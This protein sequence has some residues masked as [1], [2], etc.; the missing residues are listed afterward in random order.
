M[1]L[2]F[3]KDVKE[4]KGLTLRVVKSPV[5]DKLETLYKLLGELKGGYALIFCISATE[6][7]PYLSLPIWPPAVSIFRK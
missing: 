7:L 6:V 3:L 1:R 4:S 5:K 2:S